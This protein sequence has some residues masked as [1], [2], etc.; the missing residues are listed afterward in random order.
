MINVVRK[1]QEEYKKLNLK[2][3][4]YAHIKKDDIY[5]VFKDKIQ[6]AE[7]E[8]SVEVKR[9]G[10]ITVPLMDKVRSFYVTEGLVKYLKD[11]VH[12]EHH[13]NNYSTAGKEEN[14]NSDTVV[15]VTKKGYFTQSV[16][17]VNGR[18]INCADIEALY[19]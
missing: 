1:T 6:G 18:R 8:Y 10:L 19:H 13:P 15:A 12:I 5:I 9:E 4:R 16:Y 17:R 3:A 11:I 7:V 2:K 14:T